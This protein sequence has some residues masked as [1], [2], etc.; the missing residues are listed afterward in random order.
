MMKESL[1]FSRGQLSWL[2]LVYLLLI[3]RG[4]EREL[5]RLMLNYEKNVTTPRAFS[6]N[7]ARKWTSLGTISKKKESSPR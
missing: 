1:P 5:K 6:M 4:V 7:M 2:S 3:K